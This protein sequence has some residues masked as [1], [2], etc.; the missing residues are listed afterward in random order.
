M[1][2]YGLT[3]ILDDRHSQLPP[4]DKMAELPGLVKQLMGNKWKADRVSGPK[5]TPPIIDVIMVLKGCTVSAAQ[6]AWSA[7]SDE[8]KAELLESLKDEILKAKEK[9]EK[10]DTPS[11]DD[12]N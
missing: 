11:L 4:D 9:R 1:A 10:A 7:Q 2:V 3:K 8:R 6:K 12:V 5:T